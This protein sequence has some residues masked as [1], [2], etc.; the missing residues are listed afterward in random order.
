MRAPSTPKYRTIDPCADERAHNLRT[1]RV[2]STQVRTLAKVAAVAREC[3]VSGIVGA[4]VLLG[5]DVLNVMP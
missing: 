4:A 5:R 1:L 3:Q 2:N